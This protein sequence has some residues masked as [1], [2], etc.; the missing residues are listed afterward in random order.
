MKRKYYIDNL[1]IICILMLF[2]FHASMCFCGFDNFYDNFYIHISDNTAL[3][4]INLAVY[5]WWMSL[6]FALAGTSTFFALQKRT[7]KEYSKERA[8]R[9]LIPF[10]SGTLLFVPVQPYLADVFNNGYTGNYFEHYSVFFTR[11]TDFTGYDGGFTPGQLWFILYLYVISMLLLPVTKYCAKHTSKIYFS[12]VSRVPLVVLIIAG[13]LFLCAAS[14]IGNISGKS[15]GEF[16]ACF[17]IGFFL[18]SND[19]IIE[20]LKHN[21]IPLTIICIVVLV[22]RCAA[23]IIGIENDI[24]WFFNFRA[25]EW[26]GI[27]AA[28]A[29]GAKF[30]DFSSRFTSY[31]SPACFPLY[32]LHQSVLVGAAFFTAQIHSSVYLQFV[33]ITVLSFIVTVI[34]YEVFRRVPFLRFI[35]GIKKIKR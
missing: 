16:A 34:L 31:F 6:L 32:W 29:L 3:S 19:E 1:R 23:S 10:I 20:K 25:A 27:L 8:L 17:L 24:F 12:R 18:F 22:S 28:I 26:I 21:W 13:I 2:P 35:S 11:I 33:L 30:L 9:L 14:L 4:M 15:I 5:P 7:A